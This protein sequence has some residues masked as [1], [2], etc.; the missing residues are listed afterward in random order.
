MNTGCDPV[1]LLT[2]GP[3]DGCR[4]PPPTAAKT[5]MLA[6]LESPTTTSES[7]SPFT[8]TAIIDVGLIPETCICAVMLKAPLLLLSTVTLPAKSVTARSR[9]LWPF[10]VKVPVA[11]EN[12]A[13]PPGITTLVGAEKVAF[14]SRLLRKMLTVPV[15]STTAMSSP[16]PSPLKSPTAIAEHMASAA[17][18]PQG[19][20]PEV[21]AYS[22]AT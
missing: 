5:Q 19:V 2:K 12:G 7:P 21:I 18:V 13:V 8:S 4:F 14:P 22:G 6:V 1:K 11:I 17:L 10:R 20:P 15:E 3:T 9:Q 16:V